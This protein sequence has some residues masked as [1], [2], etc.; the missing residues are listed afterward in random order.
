MTNSIP[1]NPAATSILYTKNL[2]PFYTQKTN[3]RLLIL[4]RKSATNEDHFTRYSWHLN[5]YYFFGWK[6]QAMI[7]DGYAFDQTKSLTFGDYFNK[8]KEKQIWA[9]QDTK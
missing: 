8:Y 7:S 3:H 5:Y 1:L 2:L 6:N 9:E 4:S